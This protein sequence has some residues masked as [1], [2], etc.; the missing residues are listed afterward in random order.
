M[1]N[2]S[3][4]TLSRL[5]TVVGRIGGTDMARGAC[6]IAAGPV[7]AGGF[8]IVVLSLRVFRRYQ[9]VMDDINFLTPLGSEAP[10]LL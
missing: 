5:G 7:S 4:R 10:R 9:K 3:T 8:Q 1:S 2:S 6:W